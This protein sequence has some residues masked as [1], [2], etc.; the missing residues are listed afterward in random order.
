MHSSTNR[1]GFTRTD[2]NVTYRSA[3]ER[4]SVGFFVRNLEDELQA[5]SGIGGI[6]P[7]ERQNENTV[8]VNR[9][10]TYGITIGYDF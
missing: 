8:N 4:L 5:T 10:R 9:P 3:D 2:L 1:G 7:P 6:R